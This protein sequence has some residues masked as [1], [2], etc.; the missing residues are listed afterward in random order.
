MIV[1]A[2]IISRLSTLTTGD[3]NASGLRVLSDEYS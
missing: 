1:T 3:M 2:S